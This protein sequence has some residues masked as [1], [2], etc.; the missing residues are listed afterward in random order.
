ML[1]VEYGGMNEALVNLYAL[2]HRERHL[3]A[4]R[5]FEQPSF[6]DPLAR[7]RDELQGLHANTNVPKIIGAARSY[8][9][10]GDSRYREIGEYFLEE[11]L[12]ART[13][14]VGNTS[15]DEHWK[16]P[17]GDLAGTLSLTNAECCVAYNM[18]KLER[19][20]FGWNGDA[21]WMDAY[22]RS[23]FNCRLGTQN[24]EGLKQYF[25]PLAAG[26]WR[27]YNS[28]E[29]SFWCCTG[30]GAEEF[31]KFTDT[32]YFTGRGG[33][34]VNQF[35]ASTAEWKEG[36]LS[37]RQE[38]TFPAEQATT[39]VI[40]AA[41]AG[42]KTIYL[43]I[44]GWIGEGGSVEV[45]GRPLEA[46]A[47]P[48]SY[49]ALQRVWRTGDRVKLNLPMRLSTEALLG[50]SATQAVLYGPLVLAADLGDGPA[51]GPTK[52]LHGR[53][54]APE[55]VGAALANPAVRGANRSAG[56]APDWI[57]CVSASDLSFRARGVSGV[58]EVV[59]MYRIRDQKYAV[60]WDTS[61]T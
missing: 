9:M 17:P 60:Y 40:T 4:A 19:H 44:P 13:Y 23:L 15:E 50:A 2:T 54:T 42:R 22:E 48:G 57:D 25:F 32:I 52:I 16:T 47:E 3:A 41:P 31:A 26:Y 8:E 11:V 58:R 59:P 10:T 5:L 7:R 38:T 33:L 34:W 46:F 53:G 27:A 20:V 55:G 28:A 30:T 21:R 6:L 35:I 12:A 39:V 14:A 37:L 29:D 51:S 24:A 56:S 1:R 49:L 36:G 45:N 43:R 61:V 18:M